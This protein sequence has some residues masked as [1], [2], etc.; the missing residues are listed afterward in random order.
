MIQKRSIQSDELDDSEPVLLQTIQCYVPGSVT[1]H[2]DETN[3]EEKWHN[4]VRS[5]ATLFVNLGTDDKVCGVGCLQCSLVSSYSYYQ[6]RIY[7]FH[8]SPTSQPTWII[9]RC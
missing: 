3:D 4:G 6:T 5:V 7:I 1:A 8:V 2:L 9:Y